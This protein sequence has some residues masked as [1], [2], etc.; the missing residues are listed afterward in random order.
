MTFSRKPPCFCIWN[1]RMPWNIANKLLFISRDWL[2]QC[3]FSEAFLYSQE[4]LFLCPSTRLYIHTYIYMWA[5]VCLFCIRTLHVFEFSFCLNFLYIY[6]KRAEVVFFSFVFEGKG[7]IFF[8]CSNYLA[9]CLARV[10][11]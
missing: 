9:Y 1:S 10:K 2:Q 5:C 3:F 8:F 4:E 11:P 7:C 6:H